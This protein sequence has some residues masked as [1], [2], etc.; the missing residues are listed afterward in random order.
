[1]LYRIEHC[2]LFSSLAYNF[3][4][5]I[6]KVSISRTSLNCSNWIINFDITSTLRISLV[7]PSLINYS[8]GE[9]KNARPSTR[10]KGFFRS[11]SP[12][13]V[14]KKVFSIIFEIV[15]AYTSIT[16]NIKQYIDQCVQ[17]WSWYIL[18][19]EKGVNCKLSLLNRCFS[20]P[21][22]A[23]SPS[24]KIVWLLART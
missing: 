2:F 23:S 13:P 4:Q 9:K 3:W 5:F 21:R 20:A 7:H 19:P 18:H 24:F 1:M 11:R 22:E 17:C 15:I 16:L 6:L 10:G 8:Q 14:A 12:P